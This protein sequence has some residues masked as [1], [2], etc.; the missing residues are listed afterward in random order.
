MVS[1]YL[2]APFQ[3][4]NK[5]PHLDWAQVDSSLVHVGPHESPQVCLI[6]WLTKLSCLGH[7]KCE[8][9]QPHPSHPII[10][11]QDPHVCNTII[12]KSLPRNACLRE[13]AQ[14]VQF[15]IMIHNNLCWKVPPLPI[16]IPKCRSPNATSPYVLALQL[17]KPIAKSS[18]L[19][20]ASNS[21][22]SRQTL[23]IHWSKESCSF[24]LPIHANAM[25]VLYAPLGEGLTSIPTKS[26]IYP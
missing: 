13:Y 22:H 11:A 18:P 7:P 2:Y 12:L 15:V 23:S 5:S 4:L 10:C 20:S 24:E 21:T 6:V 1:P 3:T 25:E 9:S 26:V 17:F 14:Q 16:T 8:S 19:L